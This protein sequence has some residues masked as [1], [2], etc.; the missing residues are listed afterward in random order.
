M[1]GGTGMVRFARCGSPALLI[2]AALLVSGCAKTVDPGTV[3]DAPVLKSETKRG[4]IKLEVVFSPE[5]PAISDEVEMT[6]TIT[7]E[8]D[9]E[10][11]SLPL[12]DLFEDFL[13]ADFTSK[14]PRI[15]GDNVVVEHTFKLEPLTPGEVSL[16]SIPYSFTSE[17]REE[18]L[19]VAT[20]PLLVEVRTTLDPDTTSLA[21]LA[22]PRDPLELPPDPFRHVYW[23]AGG[24]V[25]AA[26]AVFIVLRRKQPATVEPE[27]TPAQIAR[28]DLEALRRS[29]IAETD[30]KTFF[31]EL[32]GIVSRYVEATTNV[33]APEQTTAEFLHEIEGRRLFSSRT[34][35][36]FRYFLEAAD[37][38][39]YAA[40]KPTTEEI[41]ASLRTAEAFI[42]D[43]PSLSEPAP[44]GQTPID[45]VTA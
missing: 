29:G 45:E 4:P 24:L 2:V 28:R 7:R 12:A 38:V 13:I 26:L 9:Y 22:D 19:I 34:Q 15:E 21:E 33:R 23:I 35:Q 37:L 5:S 1:S 36:K 43:A 8:K 27:L 39:K 41:G 42:S 25:L 17:G 11:Q 20:E 18:P 10:L 3:A 44:A 16:E 32:T 14:L 31:V 30:T 6:V 40:Q